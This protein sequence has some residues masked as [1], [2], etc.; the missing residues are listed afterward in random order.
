MPAGK[1]SLASEVQAL[2]QFAEAAL[3]SG[4]EAAAELRI[5]RWLAAEGPD[6]RLLHW[7]GLLLRSL[8]QRA[9]AFSALQSAAQLAPSDAGIAH[10]LARTALEA[11]LPAVSLFEAALILAP[12]SSD[13]R[14]GYIAARYGEGQGSAAR[15]ALR[16]A[17]ANNP[18]WLDGHRLFAQLSAMMGAPQQALESI[19]AA[20]LA[21]PDEMAFR[22]LA[23]DQL[24]SA[25]AYSRALEFADRAAARLGESEA[26]LRC[27]ASALDELGQTDDARAAIARLGPVADPA[28]AL[29]KIRHYLRCGDLAAAHREVLPWLS[30]PLAGEV[31][32]YMALIWRLTDVPQAQWLE[33]QS[34]LVSRTEIALRPAQL[35]TLAAQLRAIHGRSGRFLDQS[36]RNGTQ[37]DGS[38]LGRIEP[39][40][41]DLRA[42]LVAAAAQYVAALPAID[43]AHPQ[44][45]LSRAQ[46]PRIA[47]SWSVRLSDKGFHIPHHHPQGWFSAVFYVSVPPPDTS[48]GGVLELGGAPP[49]LGLDIAPQHQFSPAAGQLIIFPSTMWHGTQPITQGERLTI[50]LDIARP[51]KEA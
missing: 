24:L 27:R 39:E 11:G 1:A 34:G 47:G 50:A 45:A 4:D 7:H 40:L 44:L 29:I 16:G 41:V 3:A 10:S 36:V 18:G 22:L 35:A 38:I 32:P 51:L 33:D 13:V 30:T 17:L 9:A 21:F 37:T 6:P 19:E 48:S 49:E 15:D 28:A 42:R 12:A 14:L 43:G 8:D 26:L 46:T 5:K 2:E 20:I 25:R 23:L 31:W